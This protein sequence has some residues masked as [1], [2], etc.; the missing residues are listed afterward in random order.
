M[1][2]TRSTKPKHASVAST[3]V[4]IN[5][6]PSPSAEPVVMLRTN[7]IY[8]TCKPISGK[9]F[10][11]LPGRFPI[12]S[13][14]GMSYLLV[15][16][17]YDSNAILCK[18]MKAKTGPAI[19]ATYKT[20][21]LLLQSRGLKPQLQRLDNETSAEL[22]Q[23]MTAENIDF[24]LAPPNMHR[25]NA[26]KCAIRTFK[27]HFITILCGTDPKFPIQIWDCL[28]DQAQITLN[29]LY[30][31]HINPRLSA[32]TQ[33]HGALDFNQTPLGPLGTKIIAHNTPGKR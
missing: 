2:N 1:Q 14:R 4:G 7:S 12:Q 30:A 26:A 9:I 6:T 18:P 24:Q 23:F 13:T 25:R 28:L 31:S 17:D 3:T 32:H 29:L 10:S 19:V 33:L 21:L 5:A 8:A 22:L 27:N 11:D 16:Y 20:I 15:V